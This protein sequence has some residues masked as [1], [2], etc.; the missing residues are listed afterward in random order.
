MKALEFI[1]EEAIVPSLQAVDRNGVLEE[2]A[3]LVCGDELPVDEVCK[4]LIDREELGS[5]GVGEGLAIPHGRVPG[6][7]SIRGGLGLSREG[8]E[9]GAQDGT[10]SHVFVLLLAP[11]DSAGSHLKALARVCR[12]FRNREVTTRLLEEE[13]PARIVRLLEETEL[14]A[15]DRNGQ[16]GSGRR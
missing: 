16:P 12:V 3:A 6:L 7:G 11:E 10:L 14:A 15:H 4:I 8:I 5:T 13:S 2:L 1:R 9:F